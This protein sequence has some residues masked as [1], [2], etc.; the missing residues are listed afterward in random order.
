MSLPINVTF[1]NRS[2]FATHTGKG[3]VGEGLGKIPTNEWL[4]K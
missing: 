3:G 1:E 2:S 4:K